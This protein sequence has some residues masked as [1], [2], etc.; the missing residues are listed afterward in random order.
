M[1][2]DDVGQLRGGHASVEPEPAKILAELEIQTPDPARGLTCYELARHRHA[3]IE[4]DDAQLALTGAAAGV[5]SRSLGG[6]TGRS[7]PTVTP[8]GGA[9][10]GAAGSTAGAA[11]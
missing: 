11:G 9:T 4:P 7:D 2:T 3:A 6:D 5:V 1:D 10:V 8:G